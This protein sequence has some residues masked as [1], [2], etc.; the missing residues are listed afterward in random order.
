[1]SITVNEVAVAGTK[2]NF[3]ETITLL[4]LL[5]EEDDDD[6]DAIE[7]SKLNSKGVPIV[8]GITVL[9][10]ANRAF[11]LDAVEREDAGMDNNKVSVSPL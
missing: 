6:D 7:L 9:G 1:M 3:V 10:A 4:G 5:E 2:V 11:N 8:N